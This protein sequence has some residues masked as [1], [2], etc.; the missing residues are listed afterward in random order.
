ML[1][2]HNN[3]SETLHPIA[4]IVNLNDFNKNKYLYLNEDLEDV[5]P[6]NSI[7][8]LLSDKDLSTNQ[9]RTHIPTNMQKILIE[10]LENNIDE[11]ELLEVL[12]P[13]Y[14][15]LRL[16]QNKSLG[17]EV[18]LKTGE[19][20]IPYPS[21]GSSRRLVSGHS[22]LGKSVLMSFYAGLYLKLNPDNKVFLFTVHEDDPAYEGLNIETV[23]V[24]AE[25][26]ELNLNLN[27][28][29]NSLILIDDCDHIADKTLFKFMESL[30]NDLLTNSRKYNVHL[31]I[32]S[33]I[34][35]SG[36]NTKIT[37]SEVSYITFFLSG[38]SSYSISRLLK[39][40]LGFSKEQITKILG[41]KSRW[42]LLSISGLHLY[43]L[44]E[45]CCYII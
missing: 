15:N 33:H 31:Y 24:N 37:L 43:A 26:M 30:K 35:M 45:N 21:K 12:K 28:F 41:L 4:K 22:G 27:N 9:G 19:M 11:S 5:Q 44:T 25:T 13:M 16:K 3:E 1:S 10:A 20:F 14:Q 36:H 42:V 38:T 32:S 17:K 23:L 40:Y 7:K 6:V 34:L 18:I 39:I 8:T 29:E 2:F